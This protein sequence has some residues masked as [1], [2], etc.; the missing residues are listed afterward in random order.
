MRSF[1]RRCCFAAALTFL[2]AVSAFSQEAVFPVSD[3]RLEVVIGEEDVVRENTIAPVTV[4]LQLSSSPVDGVVRLVHRYQDAPEIHYIESVRAP[5]YSIRELSFLVKFRSGFYESLDVQVGNRGKIVARSA[6][7]WKTVAYLQESELGISDSELKRLSQNFAA[8]NPP[9]TPWWYCSIFTL[10]YTL[11]VTWSLMTW[12]TSGWSRRSCFPL[13][14]LVLMVLVSLGFGFDDARE[15]FIETTALD[16]SN[17]VHENPQREILAVY[18]GSK[19]PFSIDL[20]PDS[21]VWPIEEYG[22]H[23]VLQS[24]EIRLSDAEAR[25]IPKRGGVRFLLMS[26]AASPV[27][28]FN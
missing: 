27:W 4:R 20:H 13:A 8:A 25:L 14:G 10:F 6:A 19:K 5:A 21:V 2:S 9:R 18:L 16:P 7:R 26:E 24:L 15:G 11:F 28:T 12:K 22:G 23:E 3:I 17:K 1:L